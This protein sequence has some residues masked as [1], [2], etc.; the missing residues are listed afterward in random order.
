MVSEEDY[1]QLADSYADL[2]QDNEEIVMEY[3]SLLLSFRIISRLLW[4]FVAAV[5]V[6]LVVTSIRLHQ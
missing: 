2:L 1:K 4:G 3:D 6:T 5:V